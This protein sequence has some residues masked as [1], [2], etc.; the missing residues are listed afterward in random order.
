MFLFVG[1]GQIVTPNHSLIQ[2][3][4]A[5]FGYNI[6]LLAVIVYN[7]PSYFDYL[8]MDP[9]RLLKF[10]SADYQIKRELRP[11]ELQYFAERMVK[12]KLILDDKENDDPSRVAIN[13]VIWDTLSGE[14][15]EIFRYLISQYEKSIGMEFKGLEFRNMAKKSS[16]KKSPVTPLNQSRSNPHTT[17]L[18]ST[19]KSEGCSKLGEDL[20]KIVIGA[21]SGFD[22]QDDRSQ[23]EHLL[24]FVCTYH[25]LV[26][27]AG[28]PTKEMRKI[29]DSYYDEL[30]PKLK[31]N[32]FLI[33][34]RLEHYLRLQN[35][36][37]SNTS[38]SF[39]EGLGFVYTNL[40]IDNPTYNT[41]TFTKL[42]PAKFM[43]LSLLAQATHLSCFESLLNTNF[44]TVL[45]STK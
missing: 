36:H 15:K 45:D 19:E 18:P 31:L 10:H 12:G 16:P 4:F 30:M 37:N 7:T 34:D 8:R 22:Y 20:A 40:C 43:E 29:I 42:D 23:Q 5:V 27:T 33:Q 24:L 3:L 35:K 11:N 39:L 17:A 25:L 32:S 26:E 21:S 44:K 41:E 9:K 13:S 6:P 38:Q 14:E 2:L 1:V 28:L